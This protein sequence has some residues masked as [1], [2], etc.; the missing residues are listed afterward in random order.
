MDENT[1]NKERNLLCFEK[2][3]MGGG[4]EAEREGE[5]NS[6]KEMPSSDFYI[7]SV[8]LKLIFNVS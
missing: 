2:K 4:R 3:V 7:I 6:F 5:Q 1:Q 8:E